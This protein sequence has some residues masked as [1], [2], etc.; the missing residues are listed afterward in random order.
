MIVYWNNFGFKGFKFYYNEFPLK[1]CLT[2]VIGN[3]VRNTRFSFQKNLHFPWKSSKWKYSLTCQ[4]LHLGCKGMVGWWVF[5]FS[6]FCFVCKLIDY[7]AYRLSSMF[8]SAP[9]K[10]RKL[11]KLSSDWM[12]LCSF[13]CHSLYWLQRELILSD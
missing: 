1:W 7:I 12:K 6:L 9:M 5:F 4:R 8:N 3:M 2:F 13:S 10:D 11:W